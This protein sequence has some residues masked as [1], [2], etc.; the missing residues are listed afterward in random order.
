MQCSKALFTF[1][2]KRIVNAATLVHDQ[3]IE[4]CRALHM[5][6]IHHSYNPQ[7]PSMPPPTAPSSLSSI[8]R[9]GPAG[10]GLGEARQRKREKGLLPP[11]HLANGTCSKWIRTIQKLNA[12]AVPNEPHTSVIHS[13]QYNFWR[14]EAPCN[15]SKCVGGHTFEGGGEGMWPC[16][17]LH[18]KC[19]CNTKHGLKCGLSL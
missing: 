16:F 5:Q 2:K 12:A 17:M 9:C 19:G 11:L 18:P 15:S 8:Q 6:P 13:S 10:M 1:S 3:C 4:A 14:E 7:A